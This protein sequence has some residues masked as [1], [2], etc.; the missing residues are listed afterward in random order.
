MTKKITIASLG[1]LMICGAFSFADEILDK[2]GVRDPR[3]QVLN[4]MMNT[5]VNPSCVSG[6]QY[7]SIP[8]PTKLADI[9][10]G[11]KKALAKDAC[12]WLKDYCESG[13][14][15]AAYQR[16]RLSEKPFEKD[17]ITI[18]PE[19]VKTYTR[20]LD[21]ARTSLKAAKT[22][23]EKETWRKAVASNE[24]NLEREKQEFPRTWE[25]QRKYPELA[26]SA[27]TR[28]LR[29][30][31]AESATVDFNAALTP[32]GKLK[33]FSNPDYEK[34]SVMW[35]AIYRAGREVNE[36]TRAFVSAWLKEGVHVSTEGYVAPEDKKTET[37]TSS[38]P[39]ATGTSGTAEKTAEK[40][41][42][43][44]KKAGGLLKKIK[45]VLDR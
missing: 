36:G 25:W 40:T 29:Y 6:C 4:N 38:A 3:Y 30:Y 22:P 21:D 45:K 14:F 37:Q 13:E 41:E 11:D 28:A 1:I 35:K 17:A 34:K 43:T 10:S 23:Q 32:R 24:Y 12:Q 20:M 5:Y 31:L 44:G 9:I 26:D 19:A 39:T 16:K 15:N 18:D 27:V 33:I 42:N 2:L 8:R 7:F